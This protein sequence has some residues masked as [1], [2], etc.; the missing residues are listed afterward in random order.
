MGETRH[1]LGL[2]SSSDTLGGLRYVHSA[3]PHNGRCADADSRR[4]THSTRDVDC[5][6][7]DPYRHGRIYTHSG[8]DRNYYSPANTHGHTAAADGYATTNAHSTPNPYTNARPN[9]DAIAYPRKWTV[10]LRAGI[11]GEK[12]GMSPRQFDW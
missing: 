11:C 7:P 1:A 8:T 3:H 5:I 12:P 4:R 2:R 6:D 10:R 9:C